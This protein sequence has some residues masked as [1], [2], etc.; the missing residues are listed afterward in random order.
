MLT[1]I[2]NKKIVLQGIRNKCDGL[3][4]IPVTKRT[5]SP[6]NYEFPPIH[7][8]IYPS[9]ATKP[10]QTK[11]PFSS[12]STT[13]KNTIPQHMRRMNAVIED[14]IFQNTLD[15]Q[16]HEDIKHIQR[17]ALIHDNPSLSVIIQKRKTHMEL[18][19]YLH[20]A[21]FS[22]VRSTFI[23]AIKNNHFSTWPG[24]T[25][26]LVLKNLPKVIATTQGHL[27]QE[28]Q[29]LQSTSKI[30]SPSAIELNKIKKKLADLRKKQQP[31]QSLEEVLHQ[32]IEDDSF[33]PAP[34][35]NVCT[36]EVAYIIIKKMI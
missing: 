9:T 22:P 35:P 32:E 17:V 24:L 1:V 8:A 34:V 2:K 4:D 15:Q 30:S 13:V 16:L 26:E 23:K 33:P 5:L 6:T 10:K 14:T 25:A 7:P 28:R 12:R 29:R 36:N 27:H 18:V 20:A 21:C 11:R 3:W 31:G 19:Q